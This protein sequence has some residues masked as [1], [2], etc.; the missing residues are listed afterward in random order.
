MFALRSISS[1]CR[2]SVRASQGLSLAAALLLA[3]SVLPAS[4]QT[5]LA[6]G[7][8]AVV[9]FASDT[10]DAVSLVL[11][12][13]IEAGTEIRV[14]DNGWTNAGAF[15]SGEGVL[16]WQATEDLPAGT[17]V[18]IGAADTKTLTANYGSVTATGSFNL[19]AGGDSVLVYQGSEATPRFLYALNNVTAGTW[20]SNASNSNTSALPPGL[21]N[22]GT[23]IALVKQN[24]FAYDGAK[25]VTEGTA[26]ELLSAI[27]TAAN[28]TGN[29]TAPTAMT[30]VDPDAGETATF[31]PLPTT[32][33]GSSDASAGI[34]LDASYM[35]VGDD[36]GNVL[37]VYPR[38][39]GVAI[40]EWEF[41]SL[42]GLTKEL[43]LEAGTRIGN[44]LYFT[45]SHSNKSDGSEADNREH[46]FAADV[47][48]TGANTEFTFKGSY[49]G[50]ETQLTTWDR[51]NAHG[52]GA[53]YYG[54][55]ASS[56]DKV[57]PESAA[58][59]SIE[60]MA[61]TADGQLLLGFRAPLASAQLRNRACWARP[62]S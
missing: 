17:I 35:V 48:G 38:G 31:T 41:G 23:A 46:L 27:S 15:R 9:G 53:N 39:G 44:T 36:E 20:D 22:G 28:W 49:G 6:A 25:G 51:T 34:A 26:A 57:P 24:N 58:G 2:A 47:S 59:F 10:P 14:T 61:A 13:N 55:V 18:K 40:K 8:V 29:G 1:A 11:L 19:A 12:R 3:A 32:T 50:L 60:G 37:R 5:T 45:G 43:D 33:A 56:A 4:A 16:V 54:F 62:S 52:K 42:L 21:V 7:E 30:V